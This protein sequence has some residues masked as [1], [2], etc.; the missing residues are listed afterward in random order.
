MKK[1][2]KQKIGVLAQNIQKVFPE[3]VSK[4]ENEM[5]V[6]NYQGLV[7]ILINAIKEQNGKISRL[8]YLVKK[9][10]ADK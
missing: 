4:D 5:L 2:G 6:V 7:P 1:N 8:E 10:I 3:L 9:L